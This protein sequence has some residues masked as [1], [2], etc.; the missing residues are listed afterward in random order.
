MT[1]L[2]NH[3]AASS[4]DLAERL[5]KV[6]RT[7]DRACRRA[8]REPQT[9]ALTAVVKTQPVSVIAQAVKVGLRTFGENR[10]QEA[11]GHWSKPPSSLRGC[12]PKMELRLI[13]PLQTN[14]ADDAVALF[15]VIETVD[16]PRLVEALR[17]S[18]DRVGRCPELLVQVNTG[19]EPQKSG[20]MAH[21]LEALINAIV[22]LE[23]PL[24]GLMCIPPVDE[25]PG[26]HFALLA[27]L[28]RRYDLP[29]LSMGMS[30]D[31]ETAIRFGATHVRLGSLLFGAR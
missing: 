26:P 8:D 30:S 29:D 6:R 17:R 24:R 9:V 25:A 21:E 28:A 22:A 2:P 4:D 20:V 10:V 19:N 13:G 16:R 3:V 14:K 7:I 12:D 1:S 18:A 27:K 31:F 5:A 15:D 23:L 11:E